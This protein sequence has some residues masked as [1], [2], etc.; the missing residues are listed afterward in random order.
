M[1]SQL[2]TLNSQSVWPGVIRRYAQYLPVTAETPVITLLEGNTPLIPA[3]NFVEAIG[4]QFQLFQIGRAH[5]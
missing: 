1:N 4:G 3:P 5:V 2:S